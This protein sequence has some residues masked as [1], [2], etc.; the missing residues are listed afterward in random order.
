MRC[1]TARKL[2]SESFDGPLDPP[3]GSRLEGHLRDCAECRKVRAD[4]AAV[5]AGAR[6]F[7]TPSVPA[8]A[9]IRIRARLREAE[10][11]TERPSRGFAARPRFAPAVAALALV[12]VAA[13]GILVG[14][15]L[16]R[17][18][19]S[20]T[21]EMHEQAT[22]AKLDEAERHY[23]LAIKSLGE[24]LSGAK[25]RLSP[26]VS[27]MFT[28]NLEVVD[29]TIQACRQAVLSEPDDVR[30]RDFLLAAYMEKMALLGDLLDME[31]ADPRA[32]APGEAL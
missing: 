10:A 23:V 25:D 20:L 17:R 12:A 29:A 15:K 24:A 3:A 9:W 2:V 28:R 7:D 26:E 1:R 16:G 5:M 6:S 18:P 32:G 21:P 31:R 4:L 11:S 8:D 19:V 27:E 13:G 30:A 22:L 14:L